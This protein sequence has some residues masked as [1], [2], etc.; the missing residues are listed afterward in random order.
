MVTVVFTDVAGFTGL[1]ERLDPEVFRQVM[2]RY[3]EVM[4]AAVLRH[5]GVVEKFIGDAVAIFRFLR[6]T[7]RSRRPLQPTCASHFAS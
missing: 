1:G 2:A 5:G 4:Q 3:F 6:T 7:T